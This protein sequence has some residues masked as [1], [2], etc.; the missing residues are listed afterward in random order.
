MK[1]AKGFAVINL[2]VLFFLGFYIIIYPIVYLFPNQ[3][4]FPLLIFYDYELEL[5]FHFV[6]GFGYYL[7]VIAFS[8]CFPYTRFY[9]Q[10]A[11]KFM[12]E[13][14]SS[15]SKL[16]AIPI[17]IDRLIAE[18]EVLCYQQQTSDN[19]ILQ[20]QEIYQEFLEAKNRRKGAI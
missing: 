19:K 6:V 12:L 20:Q 2:G 15:N 10:F 11:H 18:A 17:D 14:E 13:I 16:N 5:T 3:L 4:L 9:Y 1:N 7:Q 8:C